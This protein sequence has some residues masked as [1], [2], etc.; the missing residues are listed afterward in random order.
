MCAHQ[1]REGCEAL[2]SV[3]EWVMLTP[4]PGTRPRP[5]VGVRRWPGDPAPPVL[6]GRAGPRGGPDQNRRGVWGARPRPRRRLPHSGSRSGGACA[7]GPR[8]RPSLQTH[9]SAWE[10]SRAA[11]LLT[12]ASRCPSSWRGRRGPLF[13]FLGPC[14]RA[15]AISV[16]GPG[17]E[18][19]SLAGEA[20]SLSTGR[21]SSP[22]RGSP[23][24]PDR[25]SGG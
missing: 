18:P 23:G 24:R 25:A 17:L 12:S 22:G 20:W 13:C 5:G 21:P 8:R 4:F 9:R 19:A 6:H 7:R 1:L 15:R 3:K 14:R 10:R 2:G 16:P 11:R